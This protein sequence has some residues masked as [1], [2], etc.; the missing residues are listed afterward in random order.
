LE[1]AVENAFPNGY[2]GPVHYYGEWFRAAGFTYVSPH[3]A[4]N[5]MMEKDGHGWAT[6]DELWPKYQEEGRE[7]ANS[8][9]EQAR[10]EQ[11]GWVVVD[12]DAT[13]APLAATRRDVSGT[14]IVQ[15]FRS[16]PPVAGSQIEV[17]LPDDLRETA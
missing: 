10:S 12:D 13:V 8:V 6:F 1:Y 16:A 3:A 2:G 7:M 15:V 11:E 5:F 17:R 14:R 4:A 9:Y